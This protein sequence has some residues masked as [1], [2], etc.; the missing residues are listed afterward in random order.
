MCELRY[1]RAR[2]R[3]DADQPASFR[4]R[5]RADAGGSLMWTRREAIGGAAALGATG[6][7]TSVRADARQSAD[8]ALAA[9]LEKLGGRVSVDETPEGAA[10]Y[11]ATWVSRLW[12]L[13]AFD[14]GK[15]SAEARLNF[16]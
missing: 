12:E 8:M 16:E 6:A 2:A 3:P 13:E 5:L 15:L 7:T 10:S 1:S 14:A 9:L 4:E 11:R